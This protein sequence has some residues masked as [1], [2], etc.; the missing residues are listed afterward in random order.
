MARLAGWDGN[1]G[2]TPTPTPADACPEDLNGDSQVGFQDLIQV[3]S[4]WGQTQASLEDINNDGKVNS[5]DL[6]L[7]IRWWGSC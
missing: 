1:T 3:L 2:S 5:L 4:F 6:G 7:V